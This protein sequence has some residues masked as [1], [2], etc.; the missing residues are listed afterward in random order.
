[1]KLKVY[2]E[3]LVSIVAPDLE[4]YRVGRHVEPAWAPVFYNPR[5]IVSR[6]IGVAVVAAYAR[7]TDR[8]LLIVEP[9]SATGVRGLRYLVEGAPSANL[10]LND[11]NRL[12]YTLIKYN[13]KI[14]SVIRKVKVFNTDARILL[15]FIANTHLKPDIIDID[16]FGSPV[17]FIDSAVRSIRDGGLLCVTATDLPPLLG[18]YPDTCLRKYGARSL[19]TEYAVELGAR[20][21]LGWLARECGKYGKYIEPLLTQGTDHYIRVYVRVCRGKKKS[22]SV[23]KQLGYLLHCFHCLHREVSNDL[24]GAATCP[25]CGKKLHS[26]GPLW[27]G[28]LWDSNFLQYVTKE[29]LARDYL[30]VRGAKIVRRIL[31]ESQGPP[32]FY[33]VDTIA[34]KAK[35]PHEPSPE[36]M[37]EKLRELGF[38]A[39]LTHFCDKGFRCSASAKE[40]FKLAEELS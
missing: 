34:S 28:S 23:L 37:V 24:C 6:D 14:N 20:I 21:L 17:P 5:M 19:R 10:I 1:M 35:L 16:P 2:R 27:T 22:A 3:G 7:L 39:T 29:Y 30:S 38:V 11:I 13:I 9:L 40:L 32:F 31:E 4:E 15:D 26:A 36:I 18:I 33:R 12:A 8:P 25:N